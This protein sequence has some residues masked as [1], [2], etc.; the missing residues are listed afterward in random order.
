MVD[1]LTM[2][3]RIRV[4]TR[5]VQTPSAPNPHE[6]T[7][8]VAAIFKRRGE[9]FYVLERWMKRKRKHQYEVECEFI[10]RRF[11]GPAKATQNPSRSSSRATSS[12]T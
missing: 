12:S 3:R 9:R 8:K 1:T 7:W 10:L 6:R 4:G 2:Q 11:W 5:L